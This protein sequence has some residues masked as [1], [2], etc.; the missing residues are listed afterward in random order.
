MTRLKTATIGLI[1]S[2]AACGA[3]A[4]APTLDS[5]VGKPL[6]IK[7]TTIDGK[8]FSSDDWKGKS[9]LSTSGLRG[10]RRALPRC[11]T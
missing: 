8:D 2:I 1:F 6:T 5:L 4:H 10:V 9:C 7:G 11:R 3:Q